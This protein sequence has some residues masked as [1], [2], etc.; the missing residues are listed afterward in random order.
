MVI[1]YIFFLGS[2]IIS[3]SLDNSASG[4]LVFRLEVKKEKGRSSFLYIIRLN[5]NNHIC[6]V[7]SLLGFI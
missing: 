1:S 4:G 6:T 5:G 7:F 3:L 2:L